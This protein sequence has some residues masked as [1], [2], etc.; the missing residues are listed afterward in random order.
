MTAGEYMAAVGLYDEALKL[1]PGNAAI[2]ASRAAAAVREL[3][4]STLHCFAL[5]FH[6]L[7]HCLSLVFYCLFTAFPSTFPQ[8]P[9]AFPFSCALCV[10]LPFQCF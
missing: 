1:A 2:E 5:C 6:C 3:W 9:R 4:T 10:P 8:L 7:R